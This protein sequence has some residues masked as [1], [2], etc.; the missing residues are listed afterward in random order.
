MFLKIW[1]WQRSENSGSDKL[2]EQCADDDG[3][4]VGDED[5]DGDDGGDDDD[6]PRLA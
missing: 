1:A 5:G 3:D 4:N 2:L 6:L